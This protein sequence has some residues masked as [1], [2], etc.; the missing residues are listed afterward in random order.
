VTDPAKLEALKKSCALVVEA[1]SLC[2]K[3]AGD[4]P[5]PHRGTITCPKCGGVLHY[6]AK[7]T[8]R[9]TIWGTC[10]TDNCLTWMV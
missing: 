10:G 1:M 6:L 2:L 8:A 7:A 3:D 5:R 4:H 9:G